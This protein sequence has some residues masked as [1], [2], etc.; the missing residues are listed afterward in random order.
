MVVIKNQDQTQNKS[1]WNIIW[2]ESVLKLP[3]KDT[4][5]SWNKIA[6][7]FDEWMKKDDYPGE[8]VSKIKIQKGD[9]VLDI[10]SGNG[11]ITIPLAKKARS[12]TAIDISTKML[13]L[14]R[15]KAVKEN[16]S[17]IK[18]IKSKIEDLKVDEI[19]EHDVVVASRSFNG[20]T[21][22]QLEL[23]KV[24][25][26]ARKYVYITLWGI[27]N[28]EFESKI[29]RLLGRQS[30][31]HPDYTI[32]MN[33]LKDMGIH[34]HAEPLK[35]NT[36]NFYS[37]LDDALERIQWRIGELN[38]EEKI[39]VKDYLNK[40]LTKNRD[41]TFSYSRTNSKWVLIWWKKD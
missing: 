34:A 39:Q 30:Y 11:A 38:E 13:N 25:Q 10:G 5:K 2:K 41:G 8:L 23:E 21:D 26:I 33:I 7:K 29:A 1:R 32:V 16:I 28:R 37:N 14:L 3:K 9:S 27:N 15:E 24:N 18:C 35:S 36:L 4:T 19:G 12:V 17:N 40:T 31:Q 6:T 22:I 20:I